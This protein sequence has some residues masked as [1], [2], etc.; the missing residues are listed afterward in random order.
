VPHQTNIRTNP[1]Y[2]KNTNTVAY[3]CA[4]V[5]P[6]SQVRSSAMLQLWRRCKWKERRDIGILTYASSRSVYFTDARDEA[7]RRTKIHLLCS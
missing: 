4:N 6:N 3:T 7:M 1:F 5:D 2:K